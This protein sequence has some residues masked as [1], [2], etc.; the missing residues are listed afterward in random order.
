MDMDT[1]DEELGEPQPMEQESAYSDQFWQPAREYIPQEAA[2][3]DDLFSRAPPDM[4]LS[5][6]AALGEAQH[7]C[8]AQT[9]S[10]RCLDTVMT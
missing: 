6:L 3:D 1:D 5:C 10:L 8:F 2:E 9:V 4:L 7:L